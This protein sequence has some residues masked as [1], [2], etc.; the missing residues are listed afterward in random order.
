MRH[1]ARVNGCGAVASK[2]EATNGRVGAIG[3]DDDF[4]LNDF[5]GRQLQ[6]H[7]LHRLVQLNHLTALTLQRKAVQQGSQ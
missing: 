3:T 4:A 2:C 5:A 7:A 6:R 1:E